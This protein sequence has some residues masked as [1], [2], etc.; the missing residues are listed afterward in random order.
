MNEEMIEGKGGLKLFVRSWHPTEEP[1][2]AV[3]LVHGLKAHS[4]LFD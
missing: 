1:R 4:G 3:V 2:A